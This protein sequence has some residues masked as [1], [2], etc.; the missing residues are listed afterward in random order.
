MSR[1][2]ATRESIQSVLSPTHVKGHQE[3]RQNNLTAMEKLNVRMDRLAKEILNKNLEDNMEIKDA[4]PMDKRGIIQVDLEEVPIT[5]NLSTTLQEKIARNRLLDWWDYKGRFKRQIIPNDID[6]IVMRRVGEEQSFRMNWFATKWVS[7]H[8]AVGRMMDF[9]KARDQNNCPRCGCEHENTL[10]VIRCPARESKKIWKRQVKKL[11]RWMEGKHTHKEIQANL[12]LVLRNFIKSEN[13]ES[14]IPPGLSEDI[15]T[16]FKAQSEIGWTGFLEGILSVKWATTQ[17]DFYKSIGSR[18]SGQ[19]WAT[20][21]SKQLWKMIFSMWDHRN[22]VLFESG[23]I[24][25][26]SG[27]QKVKRAI[28]RE[29]RIG[30]GNLDRGFIPYFQIS[31]QTFQSMKPIG[32]RRWFSM[33]RQAREDRGYVYSDEFVTSFPLRDWVGLSVLPQHLVQHQ[34]KEQQR[35]QQALLRQIRTGYR[36]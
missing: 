15:H 3:D 25:E 12:K 17:D 16:C 7:H 29:R 22:A 34:E 1:I 20:D 26:M 18:R 4:L 28:A 31:T 19:R 21:L 9:R 14:Y 30:L 32:L 13:F 6:W 35:R 11:C 8:I 5:S 36:H 24:D 27:I 33:I 10:H 2:I 23:K